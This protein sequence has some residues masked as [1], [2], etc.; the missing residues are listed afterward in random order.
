ML[1][2]TATY[3]QTTSLHHHCNSDEYSPSSGMADLSIQQFTIYTLYNIFL[4]IKTHGSKSR[5]Q[6]KRDDYRESFTRN[7]SINIL[8]IAH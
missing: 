1:I 3:D 7:K 4:H 5:G 6:E 8:I 2:L